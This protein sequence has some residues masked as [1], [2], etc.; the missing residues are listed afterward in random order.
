MWRIRACIRASEVERR[1]NEMNRRGDQGC[2]TRGLGNLRVLGS[3]LSAL[4]RVVGALPWRSLSE[5][6]L[7]DGDG[8][9]VPVDLAHGVL[10]HP[11]NFTSLGRS[12]AAGR[13]AF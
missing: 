2:W 1:A 3:E 12:A 4:V 7:G 10:G 6:T 9:A 13:T 5:D 8:H 11:T